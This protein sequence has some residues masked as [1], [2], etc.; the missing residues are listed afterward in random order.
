MINGHTQGRYLDDEFFWPILERAEALAVP[1]YL[2]PTPPPEAIIQHSYVGNF[3]A[4]VTQ[5]LATG[6]WGWHVETGNHILR[7]IL[8]GAFD[9]FPGLQF[10]IGHMGEIL[11]FMLPRLDATLSTEVTKLQRAPSDYL[12]QNVH[13]TF[14]GFNWTPQFLTLLLEVGVDRIMFSTDHP[15][16]SMSQATA[17][18]D[19]IPVTP[20]DRERIAHGNAEQL[21]R[22]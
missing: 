3:P 20:H 12:R 6:A 10:I 16:A 1:I 19:G 21:L 18:L 2:H 13:Y 8:S 9:R 17:F 11:P 22:V 5:L 14:A 7:I 15:Y 4:P